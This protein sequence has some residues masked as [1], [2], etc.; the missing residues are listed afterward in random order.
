MRKKVRPQDLD[1][2]LARLDLNAERLPSPCI[3]ICRI[4]SKTTF[5]EGC[6]RTIDEI[7]QWGILDEQRKRIIW[8]EIGLRHASRTPRRRFLFFR[9]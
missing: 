6:L 3:G 1:D 5:C 9:F 8:R 4:D 7:T 2:L